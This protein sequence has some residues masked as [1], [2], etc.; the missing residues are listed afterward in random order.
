MMIKDRL[1]VGARVLLRDLLHVGEAPM[2]HQLLITFL[3]MLELGRLGFVSLFQN[4][5][6]GDIHI[7]TKKQIERN[8]LER[9][10]EFDAQDAEAV[11]ASIIQEAA[12]QELLS[13]QT[14]LQVDLSGEADDVAASPQ[15]HFV[16]TVMAAASGDE[17]LPE[18]DASLEAA[19]QAVA[20]ELDQ[21][22]EAELTKAERELGLEALDVVADAPESEVVAE[23]PETHIDSLE[24]LSSEAV[25][26]EGELMA[27]D[28]NAATEI[29]GS[30]I[31]PEVE[32]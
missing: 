29:S 2:R 5:T 21:E 22:L 16:D 12:E 11:A 19:R 27:A 1:L 18:H 3:S 24:N 13:G 30:P 26:R 6:Y 20:M 31:L 32:S 23:S 14:S 8:V 10:Q 28:T 25:N 7:E 4:E 17:P 9:V 15:Q